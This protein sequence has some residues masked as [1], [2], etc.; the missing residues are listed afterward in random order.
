MRILPYIA[1]FFALILAWYGVTRAFWRVIEMNSID[2]CNRVR[3][4]RQTSIICAAL[5][6]AFYVAWCWVRLAAR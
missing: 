6:M 4:Q 1:C 2:T 5:F 3:D